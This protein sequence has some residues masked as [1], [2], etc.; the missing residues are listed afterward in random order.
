MIK[1]SYNFDI[2]NSSPSPEQSLDGVSYFDID[3][4]VD[5]WISGVTNEEKI[6]KNKNSSHIEN[7]Q[8]KG[9]PT[10]NV[11]S[12]TDKE[13]CPSLPAEGLRALGR[14]MFTTPSFGCSP[15]LSFSLA[16]I[17]SCTRGVR[18]KTDSLR[19][20]DSVDFTWRLLRV[21]YVCGGEISF[22]FLPPFIAIVKL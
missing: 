15:C 20:L 8:E 7:L 13:H 21:R 2:S 11:D 5:Y 4:T 22:G 14:F 19:R 17:S 6:T 9:N 12:G 16:L 10:E 3:N 1:C 18:V